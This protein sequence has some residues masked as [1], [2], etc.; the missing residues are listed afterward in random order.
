M[1]TIDS[2]FRNGGTIS[3]CCG[4]PVWF[5]DM[6]GDCKEH[7]TPIYDDIECEHCGDGISADEFEDGYCI[8]CEKKY[9]SIKKIE[10][11]EEFKDKL[12]KK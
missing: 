5:Q 11:E 2:D 6:C 1:D 4:A 7:C 9:G 12:F 10:G 3:D 8:G